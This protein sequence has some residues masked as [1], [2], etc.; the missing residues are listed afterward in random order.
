[1]WFKNPA[2][3]KIQTQAKKKQWI[4][5]IA[6]SHVSMSSGYV[7]RSNNRGDKQGADECSKK[8]CYEDYNSVSVEAWNS[9]CQQA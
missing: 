9:D 8:A 3:H 7:Q 1:M 6:E 5:E 2:I 4:G